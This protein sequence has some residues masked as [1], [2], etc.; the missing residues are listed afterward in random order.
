MTNSTYTRRRKIVSTVKQVAGHDPVNLPAQERPPA[1]LG[2][3]RRRVN[4]VG[5]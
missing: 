1:R 5:A 2:T 3:P 4:A